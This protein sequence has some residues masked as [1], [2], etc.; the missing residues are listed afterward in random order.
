MRKA[1]ES[2]PLFV[3]TENRCCR[4]DFRPDFIV[5]TSSLV[6][7]RYIILLYTFAQLCTTQFISAR[8]AK[9]AHK[10]VI[11]YTVVFS[12]TDALCAHKATYVS[13]RW[14]Y[15]GTYMD[16]NDLRSSSIHSSILSSSSFS[17]FSS[18]FF[19][20]FLSHSFVLA[21]LC[22]PVFLHIVINVACCSVRPH[23][24]DRFLHVYNGFPGRLRR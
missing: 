8:S 3:L 12:Y 5:R 9:R 14:I 2:V 11:Q 19:F 10:R 16:H 20:L 21:Y 1:R 18:S 4:R 24:L 17:P 7:T 15:P 23:P 22:S 6:T 13:R